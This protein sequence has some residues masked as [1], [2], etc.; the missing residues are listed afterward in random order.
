MVALFVVLTFIVFIL[1]DIFILKAQK[2]KHPAFEETSSPVFNKKSLILPKG[3]FISPGHTW[4]LA[5]HDG[6]AR[7]GIDDMIFKALG[8]ISVADLAREGAEIKRGDIIA[9]A[10]A[11]NKRFNFRSPLNGTIKSVNSD[12]LGKE[13]SDPYSNWAVQ[14]K[15]SKYNEDVKDLRTGS[16][17]A[18]WLNQEFTRFKD[19]LNANMMKPEL[20]GHTMLDGGNI[21]EGA[22]AH[23][24]QEAQEKFEKEFL[25]F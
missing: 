8:R 21:A 1:V 7:I 2:K 15:P 16:A 20:V 22:V 14:I 24:D 18:D 5:E 13:I 3:I 23:I 9:G 10:V 17:L 11:G 12:L 6:S 19:F 4:A 25:T